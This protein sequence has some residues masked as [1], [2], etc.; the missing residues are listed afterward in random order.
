MSLI[1]TGD[2]FTAKPLSSSR[3]QRLHLSPS[4]AA[5][6]CGTFQTPGLLPMARLHYLVS[7]VLASHHLLLPFPSTSSLRPIR[8]PPIPP[9]SPQL[10]SPSPLHGRALIPVGFAA[11]RKYA[12]S[13]FGQRR[14][15]SSPPMLL[16]RRRTRRPTRKAPGQLSVQIG[17]EEALPDD[18]EILVRASVLLLHSLT[19][20]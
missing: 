7:R 13:T 17:I 15:A 8:R 3:L 6:T 11:S 1:L 12:S 9:L 18:P 10:P 14:R 16:R 19:A 5:K 20:Y 4:P 2:P